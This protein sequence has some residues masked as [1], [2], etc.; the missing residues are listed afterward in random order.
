LAE[1][2]ARIGWITAGELEVHL[3]RGEQA[4]LADHH[5]LLVLL[6]D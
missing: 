2:Q 4:E 1:R 5:R 3:I 6:E